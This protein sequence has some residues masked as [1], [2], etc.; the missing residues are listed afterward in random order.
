VM[1]RLLIHH[2]RPLYKRVD[3]IPMREEPPDLDSPGAE[4]L[5]VL[6]DLL[7]RL[8]GVNPKLRTVVEMKVFHG[9]SVEHIATQMDCAP[10][11]VKL[12]WS[13]AKQWLAVELPGVKQA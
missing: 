1:R 4:T 6:E 11:T 10:I 13:F 8:E 5:S 7:S 2:A 3:K 9:L 12:Y